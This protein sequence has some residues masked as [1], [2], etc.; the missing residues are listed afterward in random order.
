MAEI[1]DLL[2]QIS[3]SLTAATTPS[4]NSQSDI[5]DVFEAYIFSILLDAA[6]EENGTVRFETVAG[7]SG[8]SIFVFRSSPGY[9]ASRSL[10]YTHAVIEF[11]GKISLE[12]HV[13]VRVQGKSK[14]LHECDVCVVERSEAILCRQNSSPGNWVHP[15]NHA[16]IISAECKFYASSFPLRY[17]RGFMGLCTELT[18]DDS[19]FIINI[20]ASSA[21][22][23]F[24]HYRKHYETGV[25][26][27]NLSK[28]NSVRHMFRERFK[29]FVNARK[30]SA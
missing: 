15:R 5:S 2:T 3:L 6:R 9:L 16:L 11:D 14:V 4:L 28:V 19:H 7:I 29:N 25:R 1:D 27:S 26:P 22:E 18:S 21:K 23:M 8:P 20:E 10:P 30:Y 13:G 17:A 24:A 12:A